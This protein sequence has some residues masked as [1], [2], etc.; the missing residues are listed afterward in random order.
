MRWIDTDDSI[1]HGRWIF[2][3]DHAEGMCTR[4]NY[5]IYGRPYQNNYLIVPY[6]Y[7][8]NCG[9]K[10]DVVSE[11]DWE[12]PKINPCLGCDDYDGRGGCRSHGGCAMD[13]EDK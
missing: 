8:P 7:C 13:E 11:D 1:K 12:E 9:C 10:M 3:P 4:C 2:S 6:N 5:K